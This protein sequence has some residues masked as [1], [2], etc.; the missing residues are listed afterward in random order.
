MKFARILC[1]VGALALAVAP[2]AL[3]TGCKTISSPFIAGDLVVVN[4]EKAIAIAFDSVD[5]FLRWE[6]AHRHAV[7]SD[8][9]K[10]A[11]ALRR[12]A[13]DAF[14]NARSVLRAY[15]TNRSPEQRALVETYLATVEELARVAATYADRNR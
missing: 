3:V 2:L 8:V 1:L 6:Y 10:A 15:K 13:P 14:R 4:S 7:P 5:T 11:D 9:T 12:K